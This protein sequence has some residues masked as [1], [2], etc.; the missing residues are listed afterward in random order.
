MELSEKGIISEKIKLGDADAMI[1]LIPDSAYRRG[2]GNELAEG[3]RNMARK[4]GGGAEKLAVHVK[5]LEMSGQDGRAHKS[6]GLTH[7][8]SVR[9]ADH[10]RSISCLDELGYVD[11]ARERYKEDA[12]TIL[13]LRSE[14]LKGILVEDMET[15]YAIVDS[16]IICKYGTMWP[17]IFYYPDYANL[18]FYTTGFKEYSD[19]KGVRKLGE[20]ICMLRRAINA[21]L[22][23]TRKDDTLP[24]KQLHE[25][26]PDGPA[27]GEVVHL[28]KM[29]DEFYDARGCTRD[30]KPKYSKLKELGLKDVGDELVRRR[31]ITEKS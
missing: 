2:L 7:A 14:E 28:D 25:P 23:V 8:I 21:K 22:G 12:K 29:L 6:I 30:G 17:P 4:L 19:V 3:V 9:G 20:R 1:N 10:L 11:I 24:Y 26:M 15:N 27:A 31:I 5:G 18:I 16:L 13:N